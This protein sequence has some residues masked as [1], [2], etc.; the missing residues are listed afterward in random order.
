MSN[1]EHEK[2]KAVSEDELL[3]DDA[4][5]DEDEDEESVDEIEVDTELFTEGLLR[6]PCFLDAPRDR[7]PDQ[8]FDLVFDAY[9]EENLLEEQDHVVELLL[10]LQ[11][12][13]S[14]FN[15]NRALEVWSHEDRQAFLVLVDELCSEAD[16][17]DAED[18]T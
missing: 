1:L 2:I 13:E 17:H 3:L 9:Q 10:H 8:L 7:T 16:A 18:A 5:D 11:E 14:P 12:E 15:L 6:F 4:S